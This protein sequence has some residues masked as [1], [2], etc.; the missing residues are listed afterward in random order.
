[1]PKSSLSGHP[2]RLSFRIP[3]EESDDA[4][5]AAAPPPE[6]G[7]AVSLSNGGDVGGLVSESVAQQP[8]TPAPD[9]GPI[10]EPQDPD[11]MFFE[12]Y[13]VNPFLDTEDDHLSTFAMD[14]DTA[15]YTVARNYLL[16]NG[17][18]PPAESI[19]PEEFI[20]YFDKKICKSRTT[21]MEVLF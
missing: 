17:F 18:L 14:V 11:A 2:H 8:A 1:M 20:N 3:A 9:S 10:P 7:A 15:S 13:G 5:F 6:P 12:D 19:R 4:V 21:L 16:Q